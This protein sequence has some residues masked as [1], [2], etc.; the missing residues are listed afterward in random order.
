[1]DYLS[2][3]LLHQYILIYDCFK[4]FK[5]SCIYISYIFIYH[6]VNMYIGS[7]FLRFQEWFNASDSVKREYFSQLRER[8]SA[9]ETRYSGRVSYVFESYP[10]LSSGF[11][12]FWSFSKG[13]CEANM[14]IR[15]AYV[16][17]FDSAGLFRKTD[18]TDNCFFFFL[19]FLF[20]ERLLFMDEYI[21]Y[22]YCFLRHF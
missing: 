6:M 21:M 18:W 15:W 17:S 2:P 5:L 19:W 20:I 12:C 4:S 9:I 7:S 14:F 22:I 13:Y 16:P 8:R 3:H 10:V 1:M 11:G